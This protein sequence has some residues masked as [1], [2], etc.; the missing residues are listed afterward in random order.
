MRLWCS[1][2]HL[3]ASTRLLEFMI[4]DQTVQPLEPLAHVGDPGCQIDPCGWPQSKHGLY[5]LQYT[6]QALERIRI[7][8]RMYF[9][10]ARARQH[11]GQPTTR[12]LLRRRFLGGQLHPYQPASRRNWS[13]P[14]LPTPLLQMEIQSAEAQTSLRRIPL[15][16]N[17]AT[18]CCTSARIRRLDAD[19]LFSTVIQLPQHR[20]VLGNRCVG[21]TLTF[22]R[23]FECLFVLIVFRT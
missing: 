1:Q 17:S 13:T 4:P 9:D 5:P 12:F 23:A 16:T 11:H 22:K 18:N 10:P 7:K 14:S 15:L 6:H 20:Q 2:N 3:H 8:I 21:Q 19:N